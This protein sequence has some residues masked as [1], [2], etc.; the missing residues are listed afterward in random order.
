[1]KTG[2]LLAISLAIGIIVTFLIGFAVGLDDIINVLQNAKPEYFILSLM[3]HLLVLTCITTRWKVIIDSTGLKIKFK[4]LFLITLAGTALSNITPSSRMGGEP[5]RAYLLN[6]EAKTTT[7]TS[8]ATIITDRIFD[9]IAFIIMSLF[10]ILLIL[11]ELNL[12][13]WI[14]SLLIISFIISI[15][16]I[17]LMIFISTNKK[18]TQKLS[19]WF[20]RNF[21]WLIKRFKSLEDFDKKFLKESD[22]YSDLARKTMKKQKIWLSG[23]IMTLLVWLFDALRTYFIFMALG[24]EVPLTL[25]LTVIVIAALI[26]AIPLFP[27]GLGLMESAMIIIY[28]SSGITLA[29]AGMSTVLDRLI[30]FWITT[31]TGLTAAYYLGIKHYK[32][33]KK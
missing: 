24:I 13:I 22:L 6:K 26:G 31:F 3:F 18:T 21:K 23:I 2:K 7:K 14:I 8:L 20:L 12:P 33:G 1:M 25:I 19:K 32:G 27:G 29:I 5:V 4:K 10:I 16:T 17:I 15:I 11:K 9:G 28:S 30:S